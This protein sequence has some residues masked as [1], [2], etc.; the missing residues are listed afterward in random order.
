MAMAP[1]TATEWSFSGSRMLDLARQQGNIQAQLAY[2]DEHRPLDVV[3]T[4]AATMAV[5]RW[6]SWDIAKHWG[7]P[8]LMGHFANLR[9]PQLPIFETQLLPQFVADVQNRNAQLYLQVEEAYNYLLAC[10]SHI[11]VAG[12]LFAGRWD[13]VST[14]NVHLSERAAR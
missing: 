5:R 14:G 7:D 3:V 6:I 8:T 12:G 13:A 11:A 1:C 2:M 4:V 9:A 10:E